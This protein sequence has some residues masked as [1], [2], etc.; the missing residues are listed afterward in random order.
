VPERKYAA[1]PD[2]I[3]AEFT[4]ARTVAPGKPRVRLELGEG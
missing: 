1:W 2:P 3:R 4:P